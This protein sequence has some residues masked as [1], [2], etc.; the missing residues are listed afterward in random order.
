MTLVPFDATLVN[1]GFGPDEWF[2]V[3]IIGF[4][5]GIDVLPELLERREGAAFLIGSRTTV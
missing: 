2:G 3:L 5:E 4:D 1:F